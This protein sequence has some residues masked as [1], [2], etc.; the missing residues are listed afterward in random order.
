MARFLRPRRI[1]SALGQFWRALQENLGGAQLAVCLYRWSIATN[2][3]ELEML[4]VPPLSFGFCHAPPK[5]F[6]L[7][8]LLARSSGSSVFR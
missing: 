4:V 2:N 7:C 6:I 1:P 3:E 8:N 5:A